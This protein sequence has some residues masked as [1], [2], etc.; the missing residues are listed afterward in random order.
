LTL[1]EKSKDGKWSAEKDGKLKSDH[2]YWKGFPKR[3][4][5]GLQLEQR[6]P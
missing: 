4:A 3:S 2:T 6:K 5:A 1:V